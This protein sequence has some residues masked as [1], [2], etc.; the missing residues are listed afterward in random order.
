[1]KFAETY[2][3]QCGEAFG[4]GDEG[5]SSCSEHLRAENERLRALLRGL[6]PYLGAIVCY[7]ST[8][9]EH[10]PNRIVAQIRAELVTLD[11]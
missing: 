1:M 10:E 5:F 7:A 4:P 8:M 2:C 3:S 9:S 11:D 6:E